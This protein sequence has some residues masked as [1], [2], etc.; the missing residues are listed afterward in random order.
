MIWYI[1][2]Y[3]EYRAKIDFLRKIKSKM[4]KVENSCS[5]EKINL[6]NARKGKGIKISL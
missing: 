3:K 5:I 6:K 4:D 1:T 2:E